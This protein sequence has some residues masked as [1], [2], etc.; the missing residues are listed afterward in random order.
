MDPQEILADLRSLDLL[1]GKDPKRGALQ[2]LARLGRLNDLL[3]FEV[4]SF[5][6]YHQQMVK[7]AAK[8]KDQDLEST[9]S[10]IVRDMRR[11][12]KRISAKTDD[13]NSMIQELENSLF[14]MIRSTDTDIST[15]ARGK[16]KKAVFG[17]D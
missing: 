17:D 11:G 9:L 12:T 13:V 6:K 4:T 1:E 15:V 7:A 16:A 10:Q 3:E 5:R 14:A 2:L 8:P